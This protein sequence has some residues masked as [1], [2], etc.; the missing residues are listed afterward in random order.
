M[1]AYA[2]LMML[3]GHFVHTLLGDAYRNPEH[4]VYATWA[5][6]RGMT[7]P[8][9]FFA[10]G[11][12]FVFLLLRDHRPFWQNERVKK[13]LRRGLQLM[14]IGYLLRL[15]F[16]Q[17]LTGYFSPE[18]L[19]VDVL[20]CIGL[21]I[22]TIIASFGLSRQARLPFPLL[23]L[24]GGL[25]LFFF[26]FDVREADWSAWPVA[27]QNYF[28]REHGSAFTPVPWMGYSLLGGLLGYTLHHRPAW[29]FGWGLPAL[30]LLLGSALH[31]YSSDWLMD[32]YRSTGWE[33][34][35]RHAYFNF[36]LKRLGH[37]FLATAIFIWLS[38]VW[39]KIPQ[40]LL[41]VGSETLAIY[42]VHYIL[43]YSSWFGIGLSAF[44]AHRLPPIAA[45][46]GALLFVIAFV[47]MTAYLH[48]IRQWRAAK[49]GRAKRYY[50]L[51][52]HRRYR[53]RAYSQ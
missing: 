12:I 21:A 28:H 47:I 10:S 36:L 30:L 19:K 49:W 32:L 20:H 14:A 26:N 33:Q 27:L 2:I 50:R 17:L 48:D 3:Q 1:R 34:F 4:P 24:S 37:V 7:A 51:W 45:V 40:L 29:A 22:L 44:W 35:R 41:K 53:R 43:L 18:V 11:L 46:V 6:L 8:I 15:N 42:E 13:G 38:Q 16:P 23:L 9:F 5:F 39:K 25:L 52:H 31:L